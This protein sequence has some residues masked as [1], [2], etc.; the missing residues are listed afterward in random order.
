MKPKKHNWIVWLSLLLA[1]GFV[2]LEPAM[3][4]GVILLS[5]HAGRGSA[6][7]AH[8]HQAE[9][10]QE[11]VDI[12]LTLPGDWECR[13]N[14]PA[15]WGEYNGT[16]ACMAVWQKDAPE[17]VF[18]I[19]YADAW[20][21]TDL[22]GE[23]PTYPV[24]SGAARTIRLPHRDWVMLVL[25][26]DPSDPTRDSNHAFIIELSGTEMLPFRF[27]TDVEPVFK[28]ILE[29]SSWTSTR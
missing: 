16:L 14:E 29:R 25:Y 28:E 11:G 7:W 6:D 5:E 9:F 17:W 13:V 19:G 3:I 2:L 24:I 4:R 1:I 26:L 15:E 12:V 27:F 10:H 23:N 8:P 18:E 20:Y 21:F 22:F